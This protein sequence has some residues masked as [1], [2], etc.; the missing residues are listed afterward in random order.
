MLAEGSSIS[1]VLFQHLL[2]STLSHTQCS[3]KQAC[4]CDLPGGDSLGS[5]LDR[6]K[7]ADWLEVEVNL[8]VG[9]NKDLSQ[10]QGEFWGQEGVQRQPTLRQ[11][12]QILK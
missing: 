8:H 4:R 6:V 3:R 1:Q 2:P 11:E 10:S 7:E 9:A 5:D 12:N